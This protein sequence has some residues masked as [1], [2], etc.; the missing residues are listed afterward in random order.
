MKKK[1]D[2]AHYSEEIDD[3]AEFAEMEEEVHAAGELQEERAV[4]ISASAQTA[5]VEEVEGTEDGGEDVNAFS[6]GTSM[7]FEEGDQLATEQGVEQEEEEAEDAEIDEAQAEAEAIRPLKR[8]ATSRREWKRA[9]RLHK[10]DT[11]SGRP[12]KVLTGDE[13]VRGDGAEAGVSSGANS[14]MFR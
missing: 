3:D 14:K 2:L 10:R 13:A 9:G 12:A 5:S 6:A 11:R 4:E 8:E 1:T 7:A